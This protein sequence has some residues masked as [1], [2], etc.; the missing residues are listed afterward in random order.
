MCYF[1][2]VFGY[3]NCVTISLLCNFMNAVIKK[4]KKIHAMGADT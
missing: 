3:Y 1:S 4:K 2:K